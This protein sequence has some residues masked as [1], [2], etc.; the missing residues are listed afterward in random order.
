M[1]IRL[2]K[3]RSIGGVLRG[4]RNEPLQTE[5]VTFQVTI[6]QAHFLSDEQQ[7]TSPTI[8][9]STTFIILVDH[10]PSTSNTTRR[11]SPVDHHIISELD[12]PTKTGN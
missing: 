3:N 2:A 6:S 12:D 10:S 1:E 5:A 9:P 11:G 4:S 8:T 7:K